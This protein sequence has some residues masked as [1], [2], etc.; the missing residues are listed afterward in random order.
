MKAAVIDEL[1]YRRNIGNV[2][3][4]S[5]NGISDTTHYHRDDK[6]INE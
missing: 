5:A 1:I 3:K 4:I 6:E 2:R